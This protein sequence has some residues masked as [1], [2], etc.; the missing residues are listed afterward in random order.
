M[1]EVLIGVIIGGLIASI[2]PII[3]IVYDYKKWKKQLKINHLK[4]KRNKLEIAYKEALEILEQCI[5]ND[6]YNIASCMKESLVE[7][8]EEIEGLLN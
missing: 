2:M 1:S 4:E 3:N 7:I 5:A 8:D 6:E